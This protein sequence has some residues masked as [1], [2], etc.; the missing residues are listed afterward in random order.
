[1]AAAPGGEGIIGVPVCIRGA[2][3]ILVEETRT[4]DLDGTARGTALQTAREGR[5]GGGNFPGKFRREFFL[6]A[7]RRGSGSPGDSPLLGSL[8]ISGWNF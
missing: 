5:T 3:V 6:G 1:M 7:C 8:G 4:I 2:R